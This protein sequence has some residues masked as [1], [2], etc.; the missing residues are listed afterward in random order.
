M[1]RLAA[2]PFLF[3]LFASVL[4]AQ[5]LTTTD[6]LFN[7]GIAASG[8]YNATSHTTGVNTVIHPTAAPSNSL[9]LMYTDPFGITS[10]SG[11]I[12]QAYSGSGS[13]ATTMSLTGLPGGGVDAYP[14]LLYGC[15]PYSDCYQNQPPQFPAQLSAFSAINI[16][17]N[18]ALTG[19]ITGK[20]V[21]LLF[22]EWVC[23]SNHPTDSSQCL[24]VEVLPYYS[25]T[26]FGGGTFVKEFTIPATINGSSSSIS[27]DEYNGGG[28]M[29]F[30][31]HGAPG[32]VG[33][34]SQELA[35]NLLSLL[36]EGVTTFGNSS[37]KYVAGIELGTEMGASSSQSYTL[38]LTKNLIQEV[39]AGSAT[40]GWTGVLAPSRAVDWSQAGIS[41][42]IPSAT[43]CGSTIAAY[44]SSGSP[45]SPSTI[46]T[47]LQ[48]CGAN[49]IAGPV[50]YVLLGP[51]DFYLNGAIYLQGAS[52]N[53]VELRGSG[54]T[55]TR[56]HFSAASTC[57]N[58]NGTCFVG[59]AT[60]SGNYVGSPGTV[61]N[62]T[63]GYA[64]GATSITVSNGAAITAGTTMLVLDQCDT[65]FT[66]A[67][68]TGS[69]VDNGNL[70]NCEAGISWSG[71]PYASSYTGCSYTGP[72]GA[73]RPNRG[74]QEIVQA[75]SCSPACG[76]AGTT[77]VTISPP[78]KHPNWASGQT[79]QMWTIPAQYNVGVRNLT[80]EGAN[81]TYPNPT[82]GIG[83][84][85]TLNY[86]VDNVVFNS[87]SNISLFVTQ[88]AAHGEIESNYI[89]FAG[90][91]PTN[92][93]SG[94]NLL[95]SSNLVDN[96]ICHN[97]LL[98]Y[99]GNGPQ[100]GSVIAYNY[101]VNADTANST[102]YESFDD[103]HSNGIDYNLYEGNVG[104]LVSMDQAHGTHLVNTFYRNFF[105]GW[106]SCA[107]GNCGS[108]TQK[109]DLLFALEPISNH[110]YGN[111]VA[112]VL[113]TP[114]VTTGYYN[115]FGNSSGPVNPS[116]WYLGSGGVGNIWNIG[117]GNTVSPPSY[118]G[119]IPYDPIV[120]ETIYRWG[121]W[122][123]KN[124]STQWNTA[125][126]PTS[127][128]S[129]VL[130]QTVP[131][132]TCT[133]SLTCPPSFYR[134]SAPSW[135]GSNPW[136]AIGPDISGGNIG[137]CNG[138]LNTAGHY[139]G[140]AA[141][142]SSQ[143]TG[144]SLAAAWGGHVNA[145]PAQKCAQSVGINV[146]GTSGFASTFD[147][148]VCYAAGPPA[149][150]APTNVNVIIP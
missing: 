143:C 3:A 85:G 117:S 137:Q 125:E 11:T 7:T 66:G 68:C 10:G 61:A 79:P 35:F 2:I 39:P 138:T 48:S 40:P 107:N 34:A 123:A 116:E 62:W 27:F 110:R 113:G 129:G 104:T 12:T 81:L 49:G 36:N 121:N 4:A 82:A 51:G 43:K 134:S 133:S 101:F 80:I 33:T 126:V 13:V 148:A 83:F 60:T 14:F 25:F 91:G 23:N 102:L 6:S 115:Y 44:G 20:D 78:L 105:A 88:G 147:A 112:N 87:L 15:D 38:T 41:G 30:Y 111:Y 122:D 8:N 74:Q 59:F 144:T 119:P 103:G 90:Q 128:P 18:Y 109:T 47:A 94:I 99:V 146:D 114:G 5:T 100:S 64:Q 108:N 118:D 142:T 75:V 67:P 28:N 84:A 24:E 131:T 71:T 37:Y 89:Y 9:W 26:E 141:F 45:A 95:G 135:W 31:P 139:S 54:P 55:Q 136:P 17:V 29:L 70:F 149:P 76:T 58:G 46:I 86:W 77:T 22:D 69:A 96:N 16:D 106:E 93:S 150:A 21:D 127:P 53:N 92:D 42:G 32:S 97:S 56:L 124:G 98:C 52:Y 130:A 50:Q 73:E 72:V 65:G 145:I 57:Q 132:T 1:I 63:A 140:L 19:T 120:A